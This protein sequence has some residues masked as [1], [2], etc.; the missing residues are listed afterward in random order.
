MKQ[1][2]ILCFSLIAFWQATAQQFEVLE[3]PD[4]YQ[5]SFNQQL[6]IPIRIKNQTDKPQFY[7]IRKVKGELGDTQKGYFC[8]NNNCLDP[9]IAEFSKKVEPGETLQDLVYT[10]E[11]GIQAVQMSIKFEFYPKGSPLEVVERAIG[12]SV[13]EKSEKS[14]IFQSKEITIQDVYPNPVQEQAFIDYKLHMESVKARITLHNILGKS[15]GDYELPPSATQIKIG[16]EELVSG[17][18]FYTVYINNSGI[19]T[20]KLIV[21]K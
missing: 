5:V 2:V 13:G 12:V 6:R 18:Y 10:L 8:F 19:L 4:T 20:R 1:L 11:S 21:R 9:N 14:F 15:M 3:T 17:V 7:I 16:A